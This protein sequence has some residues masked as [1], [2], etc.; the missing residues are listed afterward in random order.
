MRRTTASSRCRIVT[1]AGSDTFFDGCRMWQII[2]CTSAHC[3][4]P[5]VCLYSGAPP[6]LSL[7]AFL[8]WLPANCS[9]QPLAEPSAALTLKGLQ[10]VHNSKMD[11]MLCGEA[12]LC[13]VALT[14]EQPQSGSSCCKLRPCAHS[15]G[16]MQRLR[17]GGLV[18]RPWHW[19][20]ASPNLTAHA[21]SL[22]DK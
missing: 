2:I 17:H 22:K 13:V 18:I 5:K 7:L 8:E 16:C 14:C 10:G 21:C 4:G 11:P 3:T 20:I 9:L 12:M 19:H 15:R 1:A 6:H